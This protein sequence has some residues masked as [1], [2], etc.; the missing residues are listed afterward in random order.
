MTLGTDPYTW[1]LALWALAAGPSSSKVA[2][3]PCCHLVYARE[4]PGLSEGFRLNPDTG[5]LEEEASV[6]QGATTVV[7]PLCSSRS[8]LKLIAHLV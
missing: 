3:I 8:T 2:S 1:W 7:S 4:H 6:L 5:S